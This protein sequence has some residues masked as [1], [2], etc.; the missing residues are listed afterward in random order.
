VNKA[1]LIHKAFNEKH[2]CQKIHKN[3]GIFAAP[4]PGGLIIKRQ[5]LLQSRDS[6]GGCVAAVAK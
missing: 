5:Y 2:N 6:N 3:K 4:E 1:Y